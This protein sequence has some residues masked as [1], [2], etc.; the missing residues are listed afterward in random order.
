MV[1]GKDKPVKTSLLMSFKEG[2]KG[3]EDLDNR[4]TDVKSGLQT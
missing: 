3:A 1:G 2:K 4:V